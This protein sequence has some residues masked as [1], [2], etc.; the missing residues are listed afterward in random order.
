MERG[1]D[2]TQMVT[3][4]ALHQTCSLNSTEGAEA[5]QKEGNKVNILQQLN[6][7]ADKKKGL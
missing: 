7:W 3:S 5:L 2:I 6:Q 1:Q 4:E